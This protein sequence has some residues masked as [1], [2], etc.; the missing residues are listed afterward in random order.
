VAQREAA[1]RKRRRRRILLVVVLLL[2]LPAILSYG[3]WMLRPSSLPF[4]V[5]GVESRVPLVR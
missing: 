1:R 4:G 5:R 3:H 2:V